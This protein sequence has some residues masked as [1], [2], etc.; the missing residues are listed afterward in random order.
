MEGVHSGVDATNPTSGARSGSLRLAGAAD[1]PTVAIVL[2]TPLERSLA[3]NARRPDR[4]VDEQVVR[5]PVA[6]P[7]DARS[8]LPAEGFAAVHVVRAVSTVEPLG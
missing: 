4:Q 1:R 5:R 6:Q 7:T 8:R 2:D 3:Q